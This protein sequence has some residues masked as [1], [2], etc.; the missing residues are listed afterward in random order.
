MSIC[1]IPKTMLSFKVGLLIAATGRYIEFLPPFVESGQKYFLANHEVAYFIFTDTFFHPAKEK[2][3]TYPNVTLLSQNHY[4]WPLSCMLRYQNYLENRRYY[5]N[6]DYLFSC[7][8]DLLFAST[9]DER[10]LGKSVAVIHSAFVHPRVE[11]LNNATYDEYHFNSEDWSLQ[12]DSYPYEKNPI[13]AAYIDKGEY[14]FHT[15]FFG[16]TT[17]NFFTI[18]ETSYE[19]MKAD[20]KRNF[21]AIWHDESHLNRYF[22]DNPPA[23]LLPPLFACQ[24]TWLNCHKEC[25]KN[26][27]PKIWD[28]V[29]SRDYFRETKF[30]GNK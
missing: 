10:I 1:L 9:I 19:G 26:F 24:E 2:L 14:Y 17:Q 6:Y 15:C 5:E 4:P 21:L 13:S 30:R 18:I 20:L 8:A 11:N 3:K 16:G 25:H 28:V 23:L 22:H 12:K 7:D 29:K 27:Q